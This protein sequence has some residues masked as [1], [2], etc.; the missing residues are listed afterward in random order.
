MSQLGK[1]IIYQVLTAVSLILLLLPV[2]ALSVYILYSKNR[3]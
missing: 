1:N 3:Q 2:S